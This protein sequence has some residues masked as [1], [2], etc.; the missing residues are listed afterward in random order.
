MEKYGFV[1]IW[2]D[3]KHKRFY[4]GCRWGHEN[5]GYIC[6][7]PW[8]KQGYKHRPADFKRRILAFVFSNK[9]DLLEEEHKWLSKIKKEEL[10]K[11]YY[12]LHNHHFG[13]WSTDENSKLSV[14][15]KISLS[16]KEDPNW[17]RW[18]IGFNHSE[19]TK[20]K[21]RE[22]NR[23]QFENVEQREIRRQKSLELWSDPEYRRINTEN[24]KGKHQ[25]KEQIQKRI[26]SSKKRWKKQPKK[27]AS[28]TEQDKIKISKSMKNM[29]WINNG[30]INTRINKN[31]IIPDGYIK[32][33]C[34]RG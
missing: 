11:K 22:A 26:E 4:I 34:K 8:M 15:E 10:G 18:N 5:D 33:R 32:G 9:K 2:Y 29:I 17:G 28:R 6:S 7:S 30:I 16:H 21:L 1:Y 24:K 3:K 19:E 14:G 20:E 23:K 13:H 12:N 25:S 27:G 31:M